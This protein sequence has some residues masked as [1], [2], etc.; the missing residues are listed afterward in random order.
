MKRTL[1]ALSLLA[2]FASTTAYADP[3]LSGFGGDRDF[4]TLVMAPN[5]DGSSSQLTLPFRINFFGNAYSNY[6]VNNNGNISF[7]GA[8]SSF[9]PSLFPIS[10]A[11][12]IAPFWA[13]VDT[14][15]QTDNLPNP[16]MN[17]VYMAT[18]DSKTLVVTWDTVGYYDHHND[19]QNTFQLVLKDQSA[20][21]GHAGDFDMEFRYGQLQWTTG[22]ASEGTNGF[23]G[24]AAVAGWNAGAATNSYSL[25]GS[26]TQNVTGLVN[27]SNVGTD[28]VW[29][30]MVRSDEL[31]GSAPYNPV[32]PDNIDDG[33][34]GW[35]FENMPVGTGTP[36]WIDPIVATGYDY[37]ISNGPLVNGVTL[38]PGVGDGRYDIWLK[39]GGE[40]KLFASNV[41]GGEHF[42]FGKSVDEFRIT[43]IETDAAINPDSPIAFATGLWFDGVGNA[44]VTQTALTVEVLPVPEPATYGMLLAGLGMMGFAARRRR[45]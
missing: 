9:T 34:A 41:A 35:V 5:D 37:L 26:G 24:R 36:I 22:D 3:L 27:T 16:F 39:E 7:T 23:G 10:S 21:T 14:R 2:A 18:P 17:N 28:G 45:D 31:P 29:R 13:D 25:I 19:K 15:N 12:M 1:L 40:W 20:T 30:F 32:L 43:G 11:A 8:L 33:S 4:G 38:L 42:E 44:T 6:W